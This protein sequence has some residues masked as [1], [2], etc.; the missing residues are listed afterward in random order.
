MQT[1]NAHQY[2]YMN[3]DYIYSLSVLKFF[4]FVNTANDS[5][6]KYLQYL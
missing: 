4:T 2:M 5:I 6:S 1:T 3:Y